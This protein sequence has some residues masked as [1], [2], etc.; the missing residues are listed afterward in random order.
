MLVPFIPENVSAII[1]L[2]HLSSRNPPDDFLDCA[3]RQHCLNRFY[4]LKVKRVCVTKPQVLII[5]HLQR[6]ADRRQL[7]VS[8]RHVPVL[9]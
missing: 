5:I 9:Q 1:L 2:Y 8:L 6:K 3:N 7:H 4:V